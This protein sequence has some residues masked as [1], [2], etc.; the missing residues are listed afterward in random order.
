[1]LK[2]LSLLGVLAI[3]AACTSTPGQQPR[4][5]VPVFGGTEPD[6]APTPRLMLFDPTKVHKWGRVGAD[7]DKRGRLKEALSDTNWPQQ[8]IAGLLAKVANK[9]FDT[10]WVSGAESLEFVTYG[11]GVLRGVV[12]TW[13]PH[14]HYTTD[15]YTLED[16]GVR[17]VLQQVLLCR[18]WVGYREIPQPKPAARTARRLPLVECAGSSSTTCC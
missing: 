11:R 13:S 9:D 3:L 10:G 5:A 8:V 12:T 18:N 4:E 2:L 17:Y 14:T 7:P 16:N 15:R 1:M 6:P